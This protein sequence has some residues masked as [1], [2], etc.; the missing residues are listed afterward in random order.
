MNRPKALTYAY[1]AQPPWR[2]W[3]AH[4]FLSALFASA[5]AVAG[6]YLLD[7]AA[8]GC[9]TFGTTV[10]MLAYGFKELVIDQRRHKR[11]GT[12]DFQRFQDGIADYG[13]PAALWLGSFIAWLLA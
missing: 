2:S 13:F 12:W 5:A 4:L 6:V 7:G 1:W 11:A 3:I 8:L 9:W 10:P